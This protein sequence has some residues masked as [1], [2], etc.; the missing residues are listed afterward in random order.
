MTWSHLSRHWLYKLGKHF[1]VSVHL[2]PLAFLHV[3]LFLYVIVCAS[4]CHS[5][6]GSRSSP[7]TLCVPGT[8]LGLFHQ[9]PLTYWPCILF[10]Y[11]IISMTINIF[12]FAN[13]CI[14]VFLIAC[15]LPLLICSETHTHLFLGGLFRSPLLR[16]GNEWLRTCVWLPAPILSGSQLSATPSPGDLA[17]CASL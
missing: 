13:S 5:V 3:Y 7:S 6:H 12:K 1:T 16:L 17:P 14:F 8:Q 9:H 11:L 10:D 2:E 15:F 4:L